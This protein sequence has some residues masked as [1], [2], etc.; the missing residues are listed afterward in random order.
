MPPRQPVRRPRT[1]RSPRP[2]S[3]TAVAASRRSGAAS[4]CSWPV[5]LGVVVVIVI[6]VVVAVS[7]CCAAAV[8]EQ[9]CRVLAS[10]GGA[11][12]QRDRDLRSVGR[13]SGRDGQR[14]GGG[15]RVQ[16]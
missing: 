2:R 3:A 15:S 10:V 4:R 16:T 7:S 6:E 1:L 9:E 5:W 14:G 11:F 13:L 8:Q 12:E